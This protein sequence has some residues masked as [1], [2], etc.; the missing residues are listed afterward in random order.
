MSNIAKRLPRFKTVESQSAERVRV[1]AQ[2]FE[3]LQQQPNQLSTYRDEYQA[4]NAAVPALIIDAQ[5]F[6]E[7]LD[8]T[9]QQVAEKLHRQQRLLIVEQK[10]WL[11]DRARVKALELLSEREQSEVR[12][13][14]QKKQR[15]VADSLLIYKQVKSAGK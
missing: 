7:R 15:G 9:I 3:L 8:M 11:T 12:L 2:R 13:Q 14:S 4:A 10:R 5:C 1:V 6:I